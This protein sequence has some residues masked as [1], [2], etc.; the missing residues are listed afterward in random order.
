MN[1]AVN[2][3]FFEI[4]FD[5]LFPGTK[6]EIQNKINLL[7]SNKKNKILLTRNY[8]SLLE[9]YFESISSPDK[10]NKR[11]FV[12]LLIKDLE[13]EDRYISVINDVPDV[14]D[15]NESFINI[16][17]NHSEDFLFCFSNFDIKLTKKNKKSFY[18]VNIT[19]YI[20]YNENWFGLNFAS[21]HFVRMRYFNFTNNDEIEKLFSR[22][23][24]IPHKIS[25]IFI[26]DRQT[27]L[28]HKLYNSIIKK[29]NQILYYTLKA[30]CGKKRI[31]SEKFGKPYNIYTTA[32]PDN[33]HERKILFDGFIIETDEDPLN[34][35]INRDTWYICFS[36]SKNVYSKLISK[37]G[38]FNLLHEEK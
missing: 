5:S 25:K 24:S 30:D 12:E 11:N 2:K 9:Q 29:G 1:I 15:L 19:K 7:F 6:S 18:N 35:D 10:P 3:D 28:N 21:N 26:F 13:K 17:N 20:K 27:N 4:Y 31:I 32:N 22:F 23:F 8:V 37:C 34:I 33:I 16:I 36:Y 38:K 14:I